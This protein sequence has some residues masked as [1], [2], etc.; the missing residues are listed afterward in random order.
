MNNQL[1]NQNI[2]QFNRRQNYVQRLLILAMG[3]FVL[4]IFSIQVKAQAVETTVEM[5]YHNPY[6][7]RISVFDADNGRKI[8]NGHTVKRDFT[9]SWVEDFNFKCQAG[10]NLIIVTQGDRGG[11]GA[12]RATAGEYTYVHLDNSPGNPGIFRADINGHATLEYA[13]SDGNPE[14]GAHLAV[15]E[16]MTGGYAGRGITSEKGQ[17]LFNVPADLFDSA[18]VAVEWKNEGPIRLNAVLTGDHDL[19]D[20]CINDLRDGYPDADN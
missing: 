9:E 12:V 15:I 19:P 16:W 14:S 17:Y 7:A 6:G 10:Q 3:V 11:F 2:H 1:K 18:F 5:G 4:S 13:D 20:C 8:A